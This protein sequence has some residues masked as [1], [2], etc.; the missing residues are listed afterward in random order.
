MAITVTINNTACQPESD[1]TDGDGLTKFVL[2]EINLPNIVC[3]GN[4]YIDN[5]MHVATLDASIGNYSAVIRSGFSNQQFSAW[6]DYNDNGVFE[7]SEQIFQNVVVGTANADVNVPFTIPSD[8]LN[9]D[10]LMRVRG[11]WATG[12]GTLNDPC[13]DLQYGNT[14]DF[15]ATIIN[16]TLGIN[17]NLINLADFIVVSK[18]G[19]QFEAILATNEVLSEEVSIKVYSVLGQNLITDTVENS[20]GNYSYSIDMSGQASG[21]Y[22][23]RV[24]TKSFGKVQRFV[25]K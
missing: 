14:V 15:T 16:G 22:F 9:G 5:T 6:I 21:V 12:S 1:C 13:A 23:V 3:V 19:N 17:E 18:G 24:G 8:A 25:V 4:G 11:K 20:N 10:H 7:P 2:A